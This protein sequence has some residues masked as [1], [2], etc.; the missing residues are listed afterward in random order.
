MMQMH[1]PDFQRILDVIARKPT[2][3]PVLFEYA[4]DSPHIER[5][6]GVPVGTVPATFEEL[7]AFSSKAFA[8]G[9][10]DYAVI[11]P[12]PLGFY[13]FHKQNHCAGDTLTSHGSNIEGRAHGGVITDRASFESYQWPEPD[14]AD[15]DVFE[16][17][18]PRIPEGMKLIAAAPG[19]VLENLIKFM[20]Y[21]ELCIML[22]EDPALVADLTEAIGSRIYRYFERILAH[23]I[24]GAVFCNDDWGFKTQTF[25]SPDTMRR[26]IFPWYKKI[27]ALAHEHRRPAILHSCGCMDAIWEDI[28]D[29]GFDAKHSYEDAITSPERAYE[30]Y[31][32]RIA[33]LGGMDVDF[34]AR[35][36]PEEIIARS[37]HIIEQTRGGGYA[38]G[39]GNS[40]TNYIPAENFDA[41]REAANF[42]F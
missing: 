9:G 13:G 10:Y 31:G 22:D 24:V 4:I 29:M 35:A 30:L 15:W 17:V 21:E 25:L 20:G 36:T 12:R 34:L 40:I 18:V 5:L 19:G 38:L 16:R 6:A 3:C 7:L 28:F 8:A 26:L 23:D 32:H 39:S 14:A 41:M 33:I 42:R 1:K 2:A 27:A 37:R 11:T